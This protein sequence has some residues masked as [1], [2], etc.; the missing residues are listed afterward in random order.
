MKKTILNVMTLGLLVS[1][2]MAYAE[3]PFQEELDQ[4][5]TVISAAKEGPE[6]IFSALSKNGAVQELSGYRLPVGSL[7]TEILNSAVP[8][9][10][11]VFCTRAKN[12]LGTVGQVAFPYGEGFATKAVAYQAAFPYGQFIGD[13]LITG[14]SYAIY[15]FN[16]PAAHTFQVGAT[17]LN[18]AVTYL[19]FGEAVRGLTLAP[20]IEPLVKPVA[21]LGWWGVTSVAQG[22]WNFGNKLATLVSGSSSVTSS[23]NALQNGMLPIQ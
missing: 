22:M 7:E 11:Q 16:P 15:L 12:A 2:S 10:S 13:G 20:V 19:P 5:F 17:A 4:E 9:A 1:S 23:Q 6:M 14:I 8:T 3:H 18:H 21:T